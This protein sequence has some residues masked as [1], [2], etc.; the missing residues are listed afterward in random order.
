LPGYWNR[1]RFI[2]IDAA[3]AAQATETI[4]ASPWADRIH[5]F[6]EDILNYKSTEKYDCIVSNPPFFEDD[7]Q[8]AD[9]AKNNAKH[10]TALNLLQLLQV[11]DGQLTKDGFFAVLL[12]YHRVGYLIAEA[13]KTGLYL[14]KQILVK[15]TFKHKFFRGILFFSRKQT[16]PQLSEIIIRDAEHNYTPEFSAALKDYYL[17]L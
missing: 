1:H 6:N 2:G 4:A 8:S 3:A 11:F 14:S 17:F 10:D 16:E 7:L 12:P 5:I 9:E 13:E 15:Q